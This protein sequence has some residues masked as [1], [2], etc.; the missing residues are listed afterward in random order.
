MEKDSTGYTTTI[1]TADTWV[2]E[3]PTQRTTIISG[4]A[5]HGLLSMSGFVGNSAQ[6]LNKDSL[7]AVSVTHRHTY[8][9]TVNM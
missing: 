2:E 6:G 5:M 1:Y 3:G 8:T 7:P 4:G 9:H